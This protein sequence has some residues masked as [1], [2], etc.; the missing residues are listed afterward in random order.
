[1]SHARNYFIALVYYY[2]QTPYQ[3]RNPTEATNL[4]DGLERRKG[5]EHVAVGLNVA[6]PV[7][8]KP[9]ERS[10]HAGLGT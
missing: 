6:K 1:M 2:E 10:D 8:F 5:G 3:H 4:F 9:E 7:L